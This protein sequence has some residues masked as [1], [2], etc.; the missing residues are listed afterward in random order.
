MI[1]T[2]KK[3]VK[4]L[5]KNGFETYFAGGF[6]RDFV[7]NGPLTQI[8]Q[9]KIKNKNDIDIATSA[10]PND[11]EKIFDNVSNVGKSFAV[12]I[13]KENSF[14]FEI[15]SFRSDGDY[16]DGR[17]PS[18]IK[19]V[20]AKEDAQRRDFTINAIFFDPVKKKIID[21]VDGQR[22]CKNKILRFVG[23]G[24]KRVKEDH[25]RILRAIRFRNKL[26]F[27]FT[28]NTFDALKNNAKLLKKISGERIGKEM[29]N[30]LKTKMRVQA[31]W[32][33]LETKIFENI[34]PEVDAMRH[35]PQPLMWHGEG[36]VFTHTV[37][38]IKSIK[39][40]NPSAKL[41]WAM[42]LHDLGKVTKYDDTGDKISFK[43][44][45]KAGAEIGKEILKRMKFSTSF[46]KQVIFAVKNHMIFIDIPK[47]RE[48]KRRRWLLR[49]DFAFLLSVLRADLSGSHFGKSDNKM[50]IY[51]QLKKARKKIKKQFPK[52][53]KKLIS[54][55]EI[56]KILNINAGK[57]VG[58]VIK[59]INEMQILGK[60]KNEKDAI[61]FVEK[62]K[63]V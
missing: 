32:D 15:A 8:T 45:A 1:E 11:I 23:D 57:K 30:I 60:V 5:Q 61:E 48:G 31:L 38:T 19:F 51:H 39:H 47:M 33:M 25:L 3:I 9:E 17:H 20:S 18:S 62:M 28:R 37:E 63:I 54:G 46:I 22:D 49:D 12:S 44:H 53:L 59:K 2:A 13:V 6:V 16:L 35:V 24:D 27:Q 34:L 58:D 21:F 10:R 29:T 56:M 43:N 50:D 14:H 42:L 26:D 41:L 4:K 36:C 52:K 40:E 55:N 7:L